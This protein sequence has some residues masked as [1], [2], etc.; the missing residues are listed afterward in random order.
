MQYDI[1]AR[2]RDIKLYKIM[3]I[4]RSIP[5]YVKTLGHT[6]EFPGLGGIYKPIVIFDGS[7]LKFVDCILVDNCRKYVKKVKY[8]VLSV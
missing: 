5:I 2:A 1:T 7:A 4:A 8:F 3:N 6:S